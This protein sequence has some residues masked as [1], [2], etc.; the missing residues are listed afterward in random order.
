MFILAVC[1]K[2]SNEILYKDGMPDKRKTW[3]VNADREGKEP[4]RNLGDFNYT[5]SRLVE[6]KLKETEMFSG[7]TSRGTERT[8][9]TI[10]LNNW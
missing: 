1:C 5:Q 8:P 6:T 10:P 9:I 4:K 7:E 2:E 3:P